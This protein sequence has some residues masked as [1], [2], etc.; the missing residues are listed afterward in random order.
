MATG[1]TF[2]NHLLG[3]V[4]ITEPFVCIRSILSQ[5]KKEVITVISVIIFRDRDVTTS[6]CVA[7][8]TI[9]TEDVDCV[10]GVDKRPRQDRRYGL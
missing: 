7:I 4:C 6:K 5:R 3:F 8:Q 10:D 9:Q 1:T 2:V